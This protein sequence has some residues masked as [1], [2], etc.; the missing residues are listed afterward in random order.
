MVSLCSIQRFL[1]QVDAHLSVLSVDFH[2]SAE[3]VQGFNVSRRARAEG[4]AGGA[5]AP[6]LFYS[7]KK[8][9]IIT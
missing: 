3:S 1:L 5:L 2:Q 4:G 8:K 7:K 6:P 9:I